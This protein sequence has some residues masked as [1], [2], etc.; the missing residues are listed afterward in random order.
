MFK[1]IRGN[2]ENC[3]QVFSIFLKKIS[4]KIRAENSFLWI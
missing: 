2:F 4:Q 1:K 3:A